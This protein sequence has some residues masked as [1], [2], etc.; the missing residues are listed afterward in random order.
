MQLLKKN[1]ELSIIIKASCAVFITYL[2]MY[3]FR[4]PFTAAQYNNLS[5]WGVD[6]KILLIIT[7]L[8]G[9]T[10]SKY[11]GI[12]VISELTAS[13]RTI[14]LILLMAVSWVSLLFFAIVPAPYNLPFIFLN[15]LPLGMIWGVVF[16]YIEGRRHTELLGVAMA[17][18]FIISS[19]IVKGVGSYL[20]I[21]MQVSEMWMPFLTGF[22]F[23]PVLFLGVYLLHSLEQPNEDDINARTERLPMDVKQRK[24]F[25]K[26]FAP[27]I[28]F[29][30]LI[31]VCLTVFRDLRD[32]FAVEFWNSIG[33]T[34]VPT[35]LVF[36]ELPI[37]FLV[38]IIIGSMIFIKNNKNA[39]FIN[40]LIVFIGGILLLLS[41]LLF[42]NQ[43][44][45]PTYW[46][47]IVGFSMYLP[48]IAFHALF[49]ERWIAYFKI[50]SN[51]G[52]LMYVADAAG[53]LGSTLVLLF[54]N[55]NSIQYSW[56]SFFTYSA[57]ITSIFIIVL[58]IANFLYF[59][60]QDKLQII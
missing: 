54:K 55:F 42:Y 47:I 22:I 58:S 27:G 19:G 46:M 43:L 45:S 56:V 16:S 49:F 7:Q 2:S 25:L 28:L 1:T 60:K 53:Y 15:G 35:M 48:Y 50:K 24:A 11:F 18:S 44:M 9:Y 57:L 21:T 14:T 4:K 5:L 26:R 10:I 38:I 31:Y 6:Y 39:F 37:A 51:I 17:S 8:I 36:S 29:S 23:L 12:K 59:K 13:K 52:F 40:F 41:T 33:M 32:N 20:L 30:V 3:A 34:N